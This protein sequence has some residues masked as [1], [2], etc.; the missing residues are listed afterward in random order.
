MIPARQIPNAICILRSLLIGP[1]VWCLVDG[2]F[3]EALAL[4]ALAGFSDGLDGFLAKRYDW[5]TR[6]GGLLDP[7]ADKLLVMC[8]FLTLTWLGLSP[9]WLAAVVIGRDLVIV[10][11]AVTFN[12]LIER[13]RGEPSKISKLNTIFQLLYLFFVIARQAFGWPA[14]ISITVVG[15]GVL[16][17]SM[18]SGI[19]YVVRWSQRA[20]EARA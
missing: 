5:R 19:D 4:I 9:I 18:I 8:V 14:E 16:V 1:V 13:V 3:A 10:T 6:L 2:R 11:G 20:L 15:A 17:T 7:F 12:Y